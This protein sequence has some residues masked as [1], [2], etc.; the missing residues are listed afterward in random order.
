MWLGCAEVVSCVVVGIWYVMPFF[1]DN[2][3]SYCLSCRSP[4]P[5]QLL[6]TVLFY[7]KSL[8]NVFSC[9]FL[10]KVIS[11]NL[12]AFS[13][14]CLSFFYSKIVMFIVSFNTSEKMSV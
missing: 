12:S 14:V 11:I 3:T 4:E 6:E 13:E 7:Y 9:L 1:G 5:Q 2:Y 10:K 8:L